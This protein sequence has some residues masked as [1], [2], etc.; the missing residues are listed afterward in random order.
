[1]TN[2][3][4]ESLVVT[5]IARHQPR[6]RGLVRCL[7]V[8]PSD[9]DDLLQEVNKV[10]WEK[11]AEFEPGTDFWAWASQV[12]RYKAFNMVRR[13]GREVL[14][15]D[16]SLLDQL[17]ATASQKLHDLDRRREALDDCLKRLPPAQ[18]QL[19]ELRYGANQTVEAV[20]R[21]I[22]RPNGSVRQTLYRIRAALQGCI[23]GRLVAAGDAR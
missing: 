23:E 19:V 15:C 3:Q 4:R 11:A 8:R 9:V 21:A 18:R 14:I 16:E 22:G 10:L 13:Y 2:P 17:A 5:E 1:M 12:A 20:A 6:L 7:L